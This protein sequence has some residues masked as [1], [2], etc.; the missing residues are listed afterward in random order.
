MTDHKKI[1]VNL[2]ASYSAGKNADWMRNDA[3]R[4]VAHA[5]LALV[6]AVENS[7]RI[8]PS[9]TREDR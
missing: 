4:A 7:S 5:L 8:H 3:I 1:A 9:Y 6:E 2:L